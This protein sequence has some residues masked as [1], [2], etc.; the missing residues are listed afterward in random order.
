MN[1]YTASKIYN[2]I[3]LFPPNNAKTSFFGT[4]GGRVYEIKIAIPVLVS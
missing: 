3:K 2:K 4:I 1:L